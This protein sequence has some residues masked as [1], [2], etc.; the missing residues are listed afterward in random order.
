MFSLKS[1]NSLMNNCEFC[2]QND[3]M[4]CKLE[5]Q[6]KVSSCSTMVEAL[7]FANPCRRNATGDRVSPYLR[8]MTVGRSVA[9][10]RLSVWQ[11]RK[12]DPS[13]PLPEPQSPLLRSQRRLRFQFG[14]EGRRGMTTM[15]ASRVGSR[16]DFCRQSSCR[17][18]EKPPTQSVELARLKLKSISETRR[19]PHFFLPSFRVFSSCGSAGDKYQL[20]A[21]SSLLARHRVLSLWPHALTLSPTILHNLEVST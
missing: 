12:K 6:Q 17:S 3:T 9:R 14:G 5:L 13:P 21:L 15:A 19:I 7:S 18:S 8:Q 1:N 2:G 10:A 20:A 16:Y 11:N 4:Q